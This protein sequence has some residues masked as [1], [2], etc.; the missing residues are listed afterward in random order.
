MAMRG[1]GRTD[2]TIADRRR[3]V[4]RRESQDPREHAAENRCRAV[5]EAAVARRAGEAILVPALEPLAE[6]IVVVALRDVH[7]VVTVISILIRIRGAIVI[8][9]AVLPIRAAG[10]VSLLVAVTHRRA[11]E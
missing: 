6:V 2:V 4:N 10:H 11:Q 9:R 5:G 7:A 8:G 1:H 3:S